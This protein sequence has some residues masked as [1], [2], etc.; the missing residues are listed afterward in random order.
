MSQTLQAALTH[1]GQRLS[2]AG[3]E[4]FRREARILLA[5]VLE[6]DMLQVSLQLEQTLNVKQS[7]ALED[8]LK[9]RMSFGSM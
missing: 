7:A 2:A 4:D 6:V 1:A 5:F 9:L 8:A 3:V